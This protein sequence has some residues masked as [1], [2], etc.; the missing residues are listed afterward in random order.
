[1]SGPAAGGGRSESS[2]R[3]AGRSGSRHVDADDP[4]R[5][6]NRN[7]A[8]TC[9]ICVLPIPVGPTNRKAPSGR[10]G[11]VNPALIEATRSTTL[12]TASSGRGRAARGKHARRSSGSGAGGIEERRAAS[13]ELAAS[14]AS[15][16]LPPN[17]RFPLLRGLCGG[18]MGK[19][20]EIPG[21]RD[22]GRETAARAR[23]PP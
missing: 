18:R 8:S 15:T 7:S 4:V 11:S 12:S 6:P 1:M 19:P 14:V 5:Q 17:V 3:V 23:A 22:A 13:P 10:V 20:Q 16:S 2:A 21:L 9:A